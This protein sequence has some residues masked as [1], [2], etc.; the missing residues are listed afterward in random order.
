MRLIV[1][2]VALKFKHS[3]GNETEIKPCC[4]T[5]YQLEPLLSGQ[6]GSMLFHIKN[7]QSEQ[8]KLN[9]SFFR[10]FFSAGE[11]SILL[12]VSLYV[13]YGV[14]EGPRLI[15]NT[16]SHKFKKMLV[17]KTTVKKKPINTWMLLYSGKNVLDIFVVKYVMN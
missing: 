2:I 8:T 1:S 9:K 5:S 16:H 14:I 15:T 17:V 10:V 7:R 3:N 4:V 6:T 11:L 13:R 12:Y